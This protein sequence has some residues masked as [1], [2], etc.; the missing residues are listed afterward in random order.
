[1]QKILITVGILIVVAGILWPYLS[2][3]PF[4]KLPGDIVVEKEN[5]KFYFPIVSMIAASAIISLII[6]L[7]RKF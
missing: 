3:I 5:F 4:G 2:K 7:I 1:M 6:W